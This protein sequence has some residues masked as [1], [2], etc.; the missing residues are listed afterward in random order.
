[1]VPDEHDRPDEPDRQERPTQRNVRN[2]I[3]FLCLTAEYHRGCMRL[4][5]ALL[6]EVSDLRGFWKLLK[7][8][9]A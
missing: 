7:E 4:A 6:P 9:G 2:V 1:M 8:K 3:E 5:A